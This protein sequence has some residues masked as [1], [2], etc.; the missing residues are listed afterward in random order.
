MD[1]AIHAWFGYS[2]RMDERLKMIRQAGFD[3]VLLWWSDEFNTV[4]DAKEIQPELVQKHGLKIENV[5]LPF[6]N[7]NSMWQDSCIGDA[8]EAYLQQLI[9]QCPDFGIPTAVLH[10]TNGPTPPPLCSRGLD[11]FKRLVACAEQR[12]IA[13]AFENLRRVDYLDA[14]FD[15]ISSSSIGVC[16]DSGHNACFTPERDILKEYG[17]KIIAVHLHDNDGLS[18]LH[19][20]PFDG[21]IDWGTKSQDLMNLPRDLAWAL[22]V[23]NTGSEKY[24]DLTAEEFLAA[25]FT[26]LQRLKSNAI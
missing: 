8:Y 11:R 19:L 7:I 15:N 12:Q 24:K 16:Y 26:R 17:D 21:V 3:S 25:A 1:N 22:E 4:E 13:I 14:I 5:H 20:L 23:V 2:I 6:D 10:L 9:C 18:D